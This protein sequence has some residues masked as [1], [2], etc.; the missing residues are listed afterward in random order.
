MA[1]KR[2]LCLIPAKG[3]STRLPNKNILP[4][5]GHPLVAHVI[6]KAF[7]SNLF[8]KV[9]VS[10]EST[11]VADI[12]QQYG[13]EVPFI[14]PSS[15]SVDP[16]TIV[17]V[18]LHALEYFKDRGD[19]FDSLWVLLPTAPFLLVSDLLQV[20]RQLAANPSDV[21][22]SVTKTDFPP[23]NSW[24]IN[25]Q[26]FLQPCFPESPYAATKSTECPHAFRSN[27]AILVVKTDCFVR[28]KGYRSMPIA[29][30]VMPVERSIDIDTHFE[31]QLATLIAQAKLV[32]IDEG[33]F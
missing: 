4:F 14:R 16:A 25:H 26:G 1:P 27:G 11:S 8:T 3:A 7:A 5:N 18:M 21:L 23:Y 10:T 32:D 22:M 24:L 12:A 13:A 30:Y 15:L 20:Q 19:S 29:S 28:Q 9:C 2:A 6:K 31:Y 33:I 17:D